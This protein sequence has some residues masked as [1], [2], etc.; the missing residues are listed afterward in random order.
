MITK[1]V[2][3]EF[4]KNYLKKAEEFLESC[5][6]AFNNG[7]WNS[8]VINAIHCGISASDALTVFY[9]G[10]RHSGEKHEDVADL[11]KKTNLKDIKIK[12]NQLISLLSLKN[13]TEYGEVLMDK[14]N[15]ENAKKHAERFL[16]YVKSA[17]RE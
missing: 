16:S 6:K 3:K 12:I 11:L 4:Y 9:L 13:K 1:I 8:C 2:H 17:L 10:L 15:A 14:H 7:S 5:N